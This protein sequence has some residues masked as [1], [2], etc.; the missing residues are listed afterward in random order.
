MK[1]WKTTTLGLVAIAIALW[2]MHD[3]YI[4]YQTVSFHVFHVWPGQFG[5]LF[6]GWIGVHARDHSHK[7]K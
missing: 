2:S 7:D 6:A 5:L 1:S 3:T 4:P